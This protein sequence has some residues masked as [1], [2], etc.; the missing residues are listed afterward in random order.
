M[1]FIYTMFRLCIYTNIQVFVCM[2]VCIHVQTMYMPCTY[3]VCTISLCHEQEILKEKILQ[4]AGY[5]PTIVCITASC[6]NHYTTSMLASY[7]TVTVYVYCFTWL[8]RLVMRRR[9]SSTPRP[10]GCHDVSGPSINTDLFKAEVSCQAGLALAR[11]SLRP[12]TALGPGQASSW[13]GS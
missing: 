9:T 8:G 1:Y 13:L 7:R 3:M 11:N 12:E 4:R 10:P 2:F 6:L 5:E